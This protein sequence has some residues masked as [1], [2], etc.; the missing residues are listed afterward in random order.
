MLFDLINYLFDTIYFIRKNCLK[1]S[2]YWVYTS[3]NY[4]YIGL[5]QYV[6]RI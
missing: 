3:H 5:L 1:W 6:E 2:I 4:I